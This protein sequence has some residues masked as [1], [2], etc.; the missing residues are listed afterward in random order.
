MPFRVVDP[1]SS[2]SSPTF[3]V[4]R[5][6]ST[7][8][9]PHLRKIRFNSGVGV[10]LGEHHMYMGRTAWNSPAYLVG[11]ARSNSVWLATPP[12]RHRCVWWDAR[13]QSIQCRIGNLAQGRWGC[14]RRRFRARWDF[15]YQWQHGRRSKSLGPSDCLATP[16]SQ[17][18]RREITAHR[19]YL[20]GF[21]WTITQGPA[22]RFASRS[23]AISLTAA[24]YSPT[25]NPW[26]YPRTHSLSCPGPAFRMIWCCGI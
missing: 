26:P 6:H 10:V 1:E 19:I 24:H 21:G 23:L 11:T 5:P 2:R 20:S 8:Y 12:S 13:D 14:R 22:G 18:G 15:V 9:I 17:L 4:E 3:R 7:H 16:R 25:S